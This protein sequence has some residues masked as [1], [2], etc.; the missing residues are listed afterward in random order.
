MS[1]RSKIRNALVDKL[2]QINGTGTYKSNLFGNVEGKLKFWDEVNDH[3]FVC[4]TAGD[5]AR[6]YMPGSFK[7]AFLNITIRI[8]VEAE[9]PVEEL[10]TILE[11][12][13]LLLDNNNSL[14]YNNGKNSTTEITILSITT[15]E[16]AMAPQGIGE[17]VIMVRYELFGPNF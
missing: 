2:K 7:W 4:V 17:V 15:D 9:D 6:E 1:A 8:Y 16:G 11:D 14:E 5:E 3:P 10:E 12:I 13:E